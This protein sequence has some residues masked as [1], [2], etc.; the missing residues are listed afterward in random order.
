MVAWN[1]FRLLATMSKNRVQQNNN[2]NDCTEFFIF[3]FPA[4]VELSILYLQIK[5]WVNEHLRSRLFSPW[6]TDTHIYN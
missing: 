2:N 4:G 6:N 3:F 1:G 5:Y